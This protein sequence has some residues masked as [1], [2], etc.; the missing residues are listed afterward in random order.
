MAGR[1][2]DG[3][4]ARRF[5][6]ASLFAAGRLKQADIA[7]ELG[8]TAVSVHRWHRAWRSGGNLALMAA[9]RAGRRRRLRGPHLLRLEQALLEGASAHGFA[10]RVWTASRVA[11]LIEQ[12]AGVRYHRGHV[13]R[14]LRH[15][16]HWPQQRP[17]RA[18]SPRAYC[19]P[20]HE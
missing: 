9:G 4:E 14:I 5:H 15:V 11:R 18:Q 12:I 20:R 16:L 7:R 19:I 13:W 3:L 8:V 1:D 17:S 6:A 10:T 2:Y